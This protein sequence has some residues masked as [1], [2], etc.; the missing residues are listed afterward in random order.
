MLEFDLRGVRCRV[1]P[2]FPGLLAVLTAASPDAATAVCVL[3]AA[4]HECGHLL[5]M[6]A[7]GCPPDSLTMGAFG[8][9]IAA[10]RT[11][12]TGYARQAMIFLAGPLV[13]L[14]SGGALWLLGCRRAAAVHLLLAAFNLLPA[15]AL[16][17]G[18]LLR[19]ALCAAG[20]GRYAAAALRALSAVVLLPLAA[21]S[22]LLFLR[23]ANPSS[24]IVSLYLTLLVFWQPE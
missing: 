13:N 10:G 14:L 17:G 18:Q 7:C 4:M 22:F 16:D 2:L 23:G 24:V 20:G 19:C 8:M 15:A 11:R 5:A 3:A 12:R 6:A 9:R 21:G 1:S